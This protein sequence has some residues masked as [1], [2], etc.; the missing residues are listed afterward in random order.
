LITAIK[1]DLTP[2]LR[3]KKWEE[4]NKISRELRDA[5][6]PAEE[7][8]FH[9][10]MVYSVNMKRKM[11]A[12]IGHYRDRIVRWTLDPDNRKARE[13]VLNTCQLYKLENLAD[14]MVKDMTKDGVKI[15]CKNML[16][17]TSSEMPK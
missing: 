13:A 11:N 5:G 14:C 12:N 6:G 17:K 4:I 10:W 2:R 8:Q 7:F 1:G 15:T 9:A 16:I 3:D